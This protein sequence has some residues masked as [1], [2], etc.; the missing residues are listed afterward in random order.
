MAFPTEVTTL[1]S[2]RPAIRYALPHLQLLRLQCS[3]AVVAVVAFAFDF[4][5]AVVLFS[6]IVRAFSNHS[7][8]VSN[9]STVELLRFVVSFSLLLSSSSPALD[10]YFF[11]FLPSP[12]A[13]LSLYSSMNDPSNSA[14]FLRSLLD[15]RVG[16]VFF[17]GS[18]GSIFLF[19]FSLFCCDDGSKQPSLNQLSPNAPC[20][21]YFSRHALFSGARIQLSYRH[22]YYYY[23]CCCCCC[24]WW[25]P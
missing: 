16:S 1:S 5:L 23:C 18:F 10:E 8:E 4:F 21:A 17:R 2:H 20:I 6:N 15:A 7:R 13:S 22:P 3:F 11:L 24:W 19:F 14:G 12:S 9:A 25:C